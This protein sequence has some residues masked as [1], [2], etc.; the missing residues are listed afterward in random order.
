[1]NFSIAYIQVGKWLRYADLDEQYI[2]TCLYHLSGADELNC[3]NRANDEWHK[4]AAN[5]I[6]YLCVIG[7]IRGLH[8]QACDH[9]HDDMEVISKASTAIGDNLDRLRFSYLGLPARSIYRLSNETRL[10]YWLNETLNQMMADVPLRKII[11]V[12]SRKLK[13]GLQVKSKRL[14]AR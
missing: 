1:M 6:I 13:F 4:S 9:N 7:N 11:A 8:L 10:N 5:F 3:E 12:H 14:L 2:Q